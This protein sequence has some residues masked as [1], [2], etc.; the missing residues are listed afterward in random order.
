MADNQGGR[1]DPSPNCGVDGRDS[2][3][4]SILQWNCRS[5]TG[6]IPFLLDYMQSHSRADV[7]MLQSLNVQSRSLPRLDGYYYPPVTGTEDGR[8]MVATYVSTRLTYSLLDLPVKPVDCRL[9]TCAIRIPTKGRQRQTALVNVYYPSGSSKTE[10]VAWLKNLNSETDSWVVAGDFNV[11]H[12]LWDATCTAHLGSDLAETVS[13]SNLLLL[14]DGSVTRIGHRGQRSS[15]IDLTMV[16]PDLYHKA[17]WS[18]GNDHLQSDHLPIHLVLGEADPALAEV[19]RTPKYQYLKADWQRFQSVLDEQC[20]TVD[21]LD[22]CIDTY[23]ENIRNMIL[24]AAD[25]AIPKKA[26]GAGGVRQHSSKWWN[27]ECA[28]ATSAKRCALRKFQRDMSEANKEALREAAHHCQAVADKAK[29]EHWERFC[30]SRITGPEDTAKLWKRVKSFKR[31]TRQ[32]ERPLLVNDRYTQGVQEKAEALAD[33]FAK[34]SQSQ[35][36]P[37]E[38]A[39]HRA[40]EECLFKTPVMDNSTPFNGDLTTRELKTAISGLGSASKATGEDP[41]SYH[42]IRRFTESMMKTLLRFYQTCWE[43]GT[44]PAAWKKALVVAIPKD[45]KPRHL[46][47][48]Y[49]PIALTPHLGKVYERLAKNRL[50][51]VLEKRGILPVC[52]AG[53]R[54]GRSCIEQVVRLTEHVKRAFVN[55][56]KMGSTIVAT[57]FDIKRAFDTVWHA[58]LLDKMQTLGITGRLYQFVRAFLDSRQMAVQ[59]GHA[60]SQTH[61]LDMG[62]PQGSVIAPTLF[63]LMLH[64]IEEIRTSSISISLYAD[65]LAIWMER[66]QARKTKRIFLETYQECIDRVQEY[67]RLNGFELSAEKTTLMAFTRQA[68]TRGDYSIRVGDKVIKPSKEVRF[69]GVTLEQTLRWTVH[70]KN[71]ITK[72]RRATALIKLLKGETWVTPRSLIHLTNALVRSRLMYGLE[73]CHTLAESQWKELEQAELAALKV[74]LGLPKYA[75]N[76]LV[77]QEAGWLPLREECRLRCAHF[78]ARCFMV[79]NNVKEALGQDFAPARGIRRDKLARQCPLVYKAT[80][81][82]HTLTAD[83]W[84][85]SQ[86]R[87]DQVTPAPPQLIP[88]WELERPEIC[89]SLGQGL[90]KKSDP[91]YLATL[92]TEKVKEQLGNHLQIFTDGSVLEGGDTGCAFVIPDLK[93]AKRYQLPRG[94]S[95]FTAELYAILMACSTVNDMPNPPLGVAIL[96]DSKSALRALASG[97]TKNRGE[98]QAEILFLAHQ[99]IL[100]GSEVFLMWL[101]A[102]TGIRGNEMADREAKRAARAGTVTDLRPS[103][104]EIKSRTRKAVRKMREEALRQR[105]EEHGWLFLPDAH[106]HQPQLSRRALEALRRIRT[107]S[108]KFTHIAPKCQCGKEISLQH[109]FDGCVILSATLSPLWDFQKAHGLKKQEFLKPHPVLGEKPMKL[110]M[111][112]LLASE[113]GQWF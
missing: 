58:K 97:G 38:M 64:D 72:A 62:V 31:Q 63:S 108:P 10:E 102:H 5:I 89:H 60:K 6:K 75:V 59:V 7:L 32:P 30:T 47:T 111:E 88:S 44:V 53:F 16:T 8:V 22:P 2:Q 70:P 13:D 100:K 74:A 71:L 113:I 56:G 93:I 36:L 12:R 78:E 96:S 79:Q 41:I 23:F 1:G 25:A 15:A 26:L 69:L 40:E 43:S 48:S 3:T 27:E 9:S 20:E 35:H 50:E 99:L 87:P 54:K 49:R 45:G 55:G 95:I 106:L 66:D 94:T 34:A 61:T 76:D 21:P 81:P 105:C 52:Q 29:Q 82:M 80:V 98:L 85:K 46:P 65:D 110:L 67:M 24:K 90:S 77:Y 14:N 92:A 86:T 18:T 28:A 104:S 68:Q 19:D 37:E 107:V 101:P 33:V 91:L 4:L 17:Y 39:K 73:A 83:I 51:Y 103:L 42:M 112:R 57:F 109:A 84:D 11:S